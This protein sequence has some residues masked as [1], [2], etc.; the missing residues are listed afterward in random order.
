MRLLVVEDEPEL[1]EL[2]RIGLTRRGFAVDVVDTLGDAWAA[3]AA[4]RYDTLL[5]DLRLPDGDG[6]ELVRHVRGR[7]DGTPILVTTVRDATPERVRGLDDGADDYVV[8]P[9]DL[10]ELAARV[11]AVLR[12]PGRVLGRRL[13]AGGIA[14]DTATAE[15]WVCGRPLGVPRRELSLLEAL[16]RRRG[17]VVT[18]ADLDTALWASGEE[19]GP[20]A[21]EAAVSRLRRR[22]ADAGV[23]IAAVRGVGYAL[24]ASDEA[25][26]EE[27]LG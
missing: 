7:R 23:R 13:T 14:L 12:R 8:K 21:L 10:E 25:D 22:T 4:T 20:N 17:G 26:A 3:V 15:V 5:L 6:L 2:L 19:V 1:G 16:L 9:F 24:E 18:R 27:G 11:R